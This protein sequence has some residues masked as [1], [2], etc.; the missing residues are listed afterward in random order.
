MKT[1]AYALFDMDGTLV[2]SMAY[3]M[4]APLEYAKGLLPHMTEE[5]LVSFV[6]SPT[7][8]GLLEALETCGVTISVPEL[9][10]AA[11]KLMYNYYQT[12]IQA[13]PGAIPLLE[14]LHSDGVKIGII[15]MTP[16][17]DV[18]VCLAK[19]GIDKYISFVLTPEDT[20]D[21]S[22]KEKTEIFGIALEKLGGVKPEECIFY[23]DSWYAAK[24]AHEMGFRVVAA[25]DKYAEWEKLKTFA[26]EEINLDRVN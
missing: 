21:G 4:K 18:D 25:Y 22:G 15:T 9:M 16:H 11:E 24:T 2:D 19:T 6:K 17:S 20:S 3:W 5:E 23:E 8:T 14:K 1:Y 7:Y 10:H 13:K 12:E 26:D